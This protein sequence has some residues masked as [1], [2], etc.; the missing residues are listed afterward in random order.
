M[1]NKSFHERLGILIFHLKDPAKHKNPLSS[2]NPYCEALGKLFTI[3]PRVFIYGLRAIYSYIG[4][5]VSS[6]PEHHNKES[7]QI[8]WFFST[9]KNYV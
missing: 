4:D 3:S 7:T 5:M 1:S 9:H 8:F 6:V 2:K